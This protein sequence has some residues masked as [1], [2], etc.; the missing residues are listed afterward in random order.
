[1]KFGA[2]LALSVGLAMDAAAVSAARG[3]AVPA[4]RPRHA[5]L[6]ALFFGGF[7]ALM[8]VVGWVIGARIGPLV[9]AWDHWIAF[10]LLGAIGAKMLWEARGS[11]EKAPP[12]SE[13]ELFGLRIMLALAVATSIDAL[14]VGITL[15]MLEAPFALSVTTIGVTTAVL[16]VAG[17][18]LGRRAGAMLGKR[19]DVAGGLI[20]IGLG[21][22]ILVEHLGAG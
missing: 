5:L 1:M 12:R 9:E 20:L 13:A 11:K 4:V 6:V 21:V 8:P 17:L 7:Q 14:A 3:M 15:P 10:V 22:K 2:I 19:L 16:C 18:V